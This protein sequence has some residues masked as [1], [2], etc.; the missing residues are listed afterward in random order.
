MQPARPLKHQYSNG[1][2]L[3]KKNLLILNGQAKRNR[4]MLES[5]P[6]GITWRRKMIWK[7][8]LKLPPPL[9]KINHLCSISLKKLIHK[10][11]IWTQTFLKNLS[12]LSGVKT[13]C[14][15]EFVIIPPF[16]T[17]QY[18][19][20]TIINPTSRRLKISIRRLPTPRILFKTLFDLFI[21]YRSLDQFVSLCK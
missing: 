7:G 17:G 5:N 3:K 6:P 12:N 14:F 21:Y 13:I 4:A 1:M 20:I 10:I 8:E 19:T 2:I 18:L 15:L 11:I 16:C 9:Q